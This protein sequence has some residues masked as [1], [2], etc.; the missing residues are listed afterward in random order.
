MQSLDVDA[1]AAGVRASKHRCHS[2]A[3]PLRLGLL[4]NSGCNE[5]R[6]SL[7]LVHG[8][9]PAP[10]EPTARWRVSGRERARGRSEGRSSG[11]GGGGSGVSR[12][13]QQR[14]ALEALR[15]AGDGS[16]LLADIGRGDDSRVGDASDSKRAS[17]G[18][19]GDSSTGGG[20][21]TGGG[22]V[23]ADDTVV[24]VKSL[25]DLGAEV[26]DRV[27]LLLRTPLHIAAAT[28]RASVVSH[29]LACG[30]AAA[31]TDVNGWTALHVA[32]EGSTSAHHAVA[33][34]LLT[35]GLLDVNARTNKLQTPLHIT[36]IGTAPGSQQQGR[37]SG[38]AG[39]IGAALNTSVSASHVLGPVI[40]SN[41]PGDMV[42]LLHEHHADVDAVDSDGNTPL[43]VA[44]QR[45]N[46]AVLDVLLAF[47]ANVY[48]RNHSG[49]TPL[50]LAAAYSQRRAVRLLCRVRPRCAG[51]G[52]ARSLILHFSNF[53]VS[54]CVF[55][56]VAP[57]RHV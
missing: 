27:G 52:G 50:H 53:V 35:A 22:A 49:K 43:H 47:G 36:A 10:E 28:G 1:P 24:R 41:G 17:R 54:V 44:A 31:A 48:A 5:P 13:R 4:R 51:G 19:R 42:R 3:L 18:D 26:N 57:R 39:G 8:R 55:V 32:A 12:W 40:F 16:A 20:G 23:D 38:P 46:V 21:S 34:V 14:R 30:A 15:D 37:D 9:Q 56:W 25:I 2:A 45:G 29:L 6:A 7:G 33:V 11:G